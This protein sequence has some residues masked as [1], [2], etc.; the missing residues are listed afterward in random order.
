MKPDIRERIDYLGGVAAFSEASEETLGRLAEASEEVRLG[1]GE[2]LLRAGVIE[3]HAFLLLEGALRLLAKDPFSKELFTVGR[4]EAGEIIGVVDLLRQGPCE[5]AIARRPCLLLGFPMDLILQLY[6]TDP[7][8][9][10]R[11]DGLTSKCE[12]AIVLANVL[13]RLNPPPADGRQWILDNLNQEEQKNKGE[14]LNLLSSEVTGEE[15]LV[16][17][18][19]TRE[20]HE[21]LEKISNLKLR[22]W[23]WSSVNKKDGKAEIKTVSNKSN[24]VDESKK[25][26]KPTDRLDLASVGLREAESRSDLQGFKPIRGKGP[27]AANLSTLRMVARAYSTPCPIDVLEKV[28]EGAVE[29]AGSIPIQAMGQLAESMGL[30][31]QVGTVKITQLHRLELPVMVGRGSHYA[32]ITDVGKEKVLLAD[33]EQGGKKYQWKMRKLNGEMMY[34]LYC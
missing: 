12:G 27:I 4:M 31:T 20:Q 34:K 5:A 18:Q 16:G 11:L 6:R 26:W 10:R 25:S 3:T 23:K 7:G 24:Y 17:E 29:R 28:L 1:Q 15:N 32:L 33:P 14:F 22:F 19:L 9:K 2:T 8:L 30:Q 13:Q 21:K